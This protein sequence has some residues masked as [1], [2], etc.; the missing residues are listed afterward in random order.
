MKLSHKRRSF[1]IKLLLTNLFLNRTI[2]LAHTINF[3][4]LEYE[5]KQKKPTGVRIFRI[6]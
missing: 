5:I 6:F 4:N 2:T 3:L 1:I